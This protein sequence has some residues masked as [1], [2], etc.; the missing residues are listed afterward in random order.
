MKR[1]K[2]INY[3]ILGA[4]VAGLGAGIALQ[5]AGK[6]SL[7]LE[8]ESI[9]GGLN[10]SMT[11]GGCDFDIGPKILLLDSSENSK[12]ILSFLKGNYE[13]Y[14]V[15]EQTYLSGFGLLGFP[16]QRHLIDLP[17]REINKVIGDIRKV[18]NRPGVIHNFKDWLIN[19]YGEYFCNKVL[20]P[21]LEKKWQVVLSKMGY[22]WVLKRPASVSFNE[23]IQG[24]Q[25]KLPPNKFY[26]YPKVGNISLLTSA[27]ARQAGDILIDHEVT[28]IDLE[29]KY[30]IA[31]GKKFHFKYLISSLPLDFESKITTRLPRRVQKLAK[32][33]FKRLGILIF[34]LVFS[35][36][37]KPEGTAIYFPEKKFCFRRVCVLQNLCPA[38]RSS[39]QTAIS[40]EM[41]IGIKTLPNKKEILEKILFDFS[42]IHGLK[43]LGNPIFSSIQKVDFAYPLP[44]SGL[45]LAVKEFHDHCRQFNVYH[46]GRGGN[47]DYCNSDEAYK[48]GK[49]IVGTILAKKNDKQTKS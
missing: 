17:E 23:V 21:Y 2:R 35:G 7:I 12:D 9:P 27:M 30:V 25:R 37:H 28:K 19:N 6:K 5:R 34:N 8:K 45:G 18:R 14:P 15:A 38:L 40:V 42:Q 24:S 33:N 13:K 20:L 16:L 39:N 3:L 41:S 46:C 47:M 11:I 4:G 10:R 49:D 22:K 1:S 26:Y 32:K 44:L 43:D 36:R 29:K 48:Q 31:N